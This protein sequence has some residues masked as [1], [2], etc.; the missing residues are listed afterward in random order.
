MSDGLKILSTLEQP[1]FAILET[2]GHRIWSLLEPDCF[3]G[4]ASDFNL[5]HGLQVTGQWHVLGVLDCLPGPGDTSHADVGRF[6]GGDDNIFSENAAAMWHEFR[7]VFG[8]PADCWGMTPI[9]IMR[10]V[11]S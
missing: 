2:N 1:I 5:K 4:G 7:L 11:A 10:E 6:C 9:M 8:R 3:I